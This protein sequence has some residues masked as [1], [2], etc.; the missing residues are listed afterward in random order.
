[1]ESANT[2][3]LTL[4]QLEKARSLGLRASYKRVGSRWRGVVR[5]GK[6]VVA[7]AVQPS[8]NRDR[9]SKHNYSSLAWANEIIKQIII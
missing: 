8:A 1:M 4:E 5:R 7:E 9:T 3:I 6:E 2:G